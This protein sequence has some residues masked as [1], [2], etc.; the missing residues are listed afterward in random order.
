[1]AKIKEI[2][3]KD[4]KRNGSNYRMK[5]DEIGGMATPRDFSGL[6]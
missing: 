3:I 5:I 6:D 4:Y 1:M 2:K